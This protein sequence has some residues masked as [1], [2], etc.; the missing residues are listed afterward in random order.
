[1]IIPPANIILSNQYTAGNEYIYAES[2]QPYQGYYYELNSKF[3]VGKTFN[4]SSPELIKVNS[5]AAT[6]P[7]KSNPSSSLYSDF[8]GKDLPNGNLTSIDI[9][10][11]S[12]GIRYIAKKNNSSK[13]F[14]ISEEDYDNNQ[15]NPLYTLVKISYD[16]EFGFFP[17]IDDLTRMPEL[18]SLVGEYSNR[19]DDDL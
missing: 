1:M 12:D 8:Y 5:A 17:S 19:D 2:R 14:F 3:F 11:G 15:N 10:D 6:N 13:I 18:G 16:P 4:S 9:S 7:L